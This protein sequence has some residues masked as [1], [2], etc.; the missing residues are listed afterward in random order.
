VIVDTS[1]LFDSLVD[2]PL[3]DAARALIQSDLPLRCPDLVHVEIAGALTRAVRRGELT[4][5]AAEILYPIAR[6]ILPETDAA[7]GFI[8]RAFALSLELRHPLSDCVF[9]AQAEAQGDVL[10]TTDERLLRKL[11][12]GRHASL[13]VHLKD[14]SS[15]A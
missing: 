1:V 8:P 13:A 11:E 7:D 6:G 2:A 9:L 4:A 10:V 3:S 14:W 12:G 15:R 5:H